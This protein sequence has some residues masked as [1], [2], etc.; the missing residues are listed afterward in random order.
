MPAEDHVFRG[1]DRAR[2]DDVL[3]ATERAARD[4]RDARGTAPTKRGVAPDVVHTAIALMA[5][6]E[7]KPLTAVAF[8]HRLAKTTGNPELYVAV[9]GLIEDAFRPWLTEAIDSNKLREI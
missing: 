4:R 9:M 6:A 3:I 8:A 5:Q 1:Q 7:G 2:P